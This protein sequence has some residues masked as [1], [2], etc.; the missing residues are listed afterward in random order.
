MIF[1]FGLHQKAISE[2]NASAHFQAFV[3][4]AGL[5]FAVDLDIQH[6]KQINT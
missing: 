1:K 6:Y 4:A 2:H 3:A 5:L